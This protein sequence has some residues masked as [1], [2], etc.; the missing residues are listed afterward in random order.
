MNTLMSETKLS[1]ILNHEN[2]LPLVVGTN[3]KEYHTNGQ[4][5]LFTYLTCIALCDLLGGSGKPEIE[6]YFAKPKEKGKDIKISLFKSAS[7]IGSEMGMTG[8]RMAIGAAVN[9]LLCKKGLLQWNVQANRYEPTDKGKPISREVHQSRVVDG[10]MK[11]ISFFKWNPEEV[12]LI[13]A[14]REEPVM[15]KLGS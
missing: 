5:I 12:K 10:E 7:L 8:D 3:G 13:L 2:L 1:R 6:I 4:M 9:K 14:K 11:S 15:R